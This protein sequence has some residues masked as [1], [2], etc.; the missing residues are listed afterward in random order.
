METANLRTR[1]FAKKRER[2]ARIKGAL[3]DWGRVK[4]R[5]DPDEDYGLP[6]GMDVTYL[7][8]EPKEIEEAASTAAQ[9][10]TL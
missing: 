7:L 3:S 4:R 10:T 2:I 5:G 1:Y 6:P 8:T 9:V